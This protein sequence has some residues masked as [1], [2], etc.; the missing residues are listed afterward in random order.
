M[1]RLDW[2][3]AMGSPALVSSEAGRFED[4]RVDT[5]GGVRCPTGREKERSPLV[6]CCNSS[7]SSSEVSCSGE[8]EI[9]RL[10][11]AGIS[12]SLSSASRHCCISSISS[13][14]PQSSSYRNDMDRSWTSTRRS[15]SAVRWWRLMVSSWPWFTGRWLASRKG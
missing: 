12:S 11:S 7:S 6:S 14:K 1:G 10:G 4:D 8:L 15:F 5:L 9:R 2:R 13:K 3:F